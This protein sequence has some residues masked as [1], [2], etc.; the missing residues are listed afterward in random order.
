MIDTPKVLIVDDDDILRRIYKAMLSGE[1]EVI[2]AKNGKEGVEAYLANFPDVVL[3]DVVMPIMDGI[4]ATK[5]ILKINPDA[6]VI[7][8]TAYAPEKGTKMLEAGAKDVIPKPIKRE[9]FIEK[10]RKIMRSR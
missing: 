5:E 2:E 3:M 4:E 1:F 8:V 9:E 7:G 6:I 10:I